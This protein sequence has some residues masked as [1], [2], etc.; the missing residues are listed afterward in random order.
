MHPTWLT[1][2]LDLPDAG[3][4]PGRRFWP[5]ATGYSLSPPRGERGEFV[6][7]VP[8]T[9]GTHLKIQRREA[10]ASGVHLDLRVE[11]LDGGI[12]HA[13]GAGASLVAR[14]GHAILRSP[15]GFVFCLVTHPENTPAPPGEWGTHRS[16]VDQL[17]IDVAPAAWDR[18]KAFWS[19]LT[20]WTVAQAGGSEFARLRT[21]PEIRV[22]ILL[23]R[24][25]E[26]GTGGHV[27]IA[28]D[29]RTREVERLVALGAAVV[30]QRY[31]WTVMAGPDGSVF[32][33]T[34]RDPD[35]G[36]VA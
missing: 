9:G 33:V 30:R 27:D 6:S 28:T 2:F 5:A 19:D 24:L 16:V 35:T 8:P 3:D 13:I 20:G 17:A 23:H 21:P 11:D 34:D 36:L 14:P 18:E 31:A 4:P 22:R 1:I 15:S 10:G 25:D 29:D 12:G 32:C 26:G 7:L